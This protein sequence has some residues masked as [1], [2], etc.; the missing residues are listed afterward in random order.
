MA[1]LNW[2]VCSHAGRQY[3]IGVYH[4]A[5]TGHLVV[6][7]NSTVVIIDFNVVQAKT[8]SF[9]LDNNLCEL[10]IAPKGDAYDYVLDLNDPVDMPAPEPK[11]GERY[12]Y[13]ALGA[14]LIFFLTIYLLT[15]W[16]SPQIPQ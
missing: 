7:C 3:T 11:G 15:F 13:Y 14:A 12:H 8:Y 1:Q 9:M 16:L 4:G 6:H 10:S 5:E 2:N